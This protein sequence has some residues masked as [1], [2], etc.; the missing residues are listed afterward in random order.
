MNKK[1]N[2]KTFIDE[3]YS[4][5]PMKNYPTNKIV[6]NHIDERWSTDLLDMSDYGISK[7]KGYRYI[8]VIDN[9]S[10]YTWCIPLKNEYG[11]TIRDEFSNIISAIKR[12]PNK[13]ESDRGREVYNN[14]SHFFET[15]KYTSLI[16]L[17]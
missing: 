12:K 13:I 7:N 15:R 5:P 16:S 8:L 2:I 17:F 6:Y 14:N 1:D 10:K 4:P 3:M 11:Q 9:F